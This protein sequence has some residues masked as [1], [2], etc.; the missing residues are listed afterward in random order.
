[1]ISKLYNKLKESKARSYLRRPI[2]NKDPERYKEIAHEWPICNILL[3]KVPNNSN[4][5][6]HNAGIKI[7]GWIGDAGLLVCMIAYPKIF[8]I[9]LITIM[10]TTIGTIYGI[11]IMLYLDFWNTSRRFNLVKYRFG[12]LI[13]MLLVICLSIFLFIGHLYF[14]GTLFNMPDL[15][16]FK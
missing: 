5:E 12:A 7:S 10:I 8:S 13:S 4:T 9:V 11:R 16:R 14:F 15:Y 1:M 2:L 6:D 3:P